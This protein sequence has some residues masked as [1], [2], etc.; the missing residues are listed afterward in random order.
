MADAAEFVADDSE[1]AGLGRCQDDDVLVA[2]MNLDVDVGRLQR[3]AMLPV[4]RRQMQAIA[5]PLLQLQHRPPLPEPPEEI[6][7]DTGRRPHHRRAGIVA[8]LILLGEFVD[9]ILIDAR[10]DAIGFA[11]KILTA[12][13]MPGDHEE[14]HEQT[15]QQRHGDPDQFDALDRFIPPDT[16]LGRGNGHRSRSYLPTGT[17]ATSIT[18]QT[19]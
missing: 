15:P 13:E 12:D 2:G 11:R 17:L 18:P 14:E 19:M 8:D 1:F 6:D 10:H 9:L 5:L 4:G 16:A 7:V 3:E